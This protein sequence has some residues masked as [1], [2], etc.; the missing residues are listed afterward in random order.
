[1]SLKPNTY[2][3]GMNVYA[4]GISVKVSVH[5]PGRSVPNNGQKSAEGIVV[6]T[7]S[8]LMKA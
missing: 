1:M 4:T 6:K 3:E 2:P 5:Y 8:V 7:K